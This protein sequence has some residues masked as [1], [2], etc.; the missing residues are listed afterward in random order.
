[1]LWYSTDSMKMDYADDP[2]LA[3]HLEKSK[4]NLVV[5]FN[6]HY[7]NKA[8]TTSTLSS[9]AS[10]SMPTPPSVGSPLK[11]FTAHYRRKEKTAVNEL[12]EYFKLPTE[13]FNTCN[14]IQW[15]MGQQAQ[16]PNLFC[17]ARDIL[18][19]PSK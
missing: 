13:D 14:P 18:C 7:A 16:L 2:I 5:Y 9:L 15:W 4:S 1:M 10:P 8:I 17:L 6:E 11:C 12:E 3:D 19:I